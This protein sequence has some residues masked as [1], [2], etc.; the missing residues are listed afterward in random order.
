[1]SEPSLPRPRPCASCPYRK[2]VPS[3]VWAAVEYDKLPGYDGEIIDQVMA[4]KTNVFD[5]HQA[6]GKV[7]SGWLGHRE[8]PTDLLA[9]RLGLSSGSLDESCCDYSTDVPLFASGAEA[10][11]HGKRDIEQPSE[12]ANEIVAKVI[13]VRDARGVPVEYAR[14]SQS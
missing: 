2:D 12:K 9:V 8:D 3:G 4:G 1:M 7:C 6:D 14:D 11:E 10:A 13:R 5:C